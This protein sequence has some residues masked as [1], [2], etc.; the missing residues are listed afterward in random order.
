[1][2]IL[3]FDSV[4][5]QYLYFNE[6]YGNHKFIDIEN[7]NLIWTFENVD[8]QTCYL[9]SK[10]LD[11]IESNLSEAIELINSRRANQISLI[12]DLTRDIFDFEKELLFEHSFSKSVLHCQKGSVKQQDY[13]KFQF[14]TIQ[15]KDALKKL[16]GSSS[17][18]QAQIKKYEHQLLF[19]MDQSFFSI[20]HVSSQGQASVGMLV[21][22]FNVKDFKIIEY[23]NVDW[24]TSD[25]TD[26]ISIALHRE[27]DNNFPITFFIID[28][29]FSSLIDKTFVDEESEILYYEKKAIQKRPFHFEKVST[30]DTLRNDEAYIT[31]TELLQ[32]IGV[33][34]HNDLPKNW[35]SVTALSIIIRDKTIKSTMPILDAGGEYYSAITHQLAAFGYE[36][37]HCINTVFE[38]NS[39]IGEVHYLP[40]DITGTDFE[41][42]TFMAITCLSVIE[43]GVDIDKY[44]SEMSRILK[45]GGILFTST[46]YWIKPVDTFGK[47]AYGVPIK[48]F[49]KVD[50]EDIIIKAKTYGLALID[51]IN[52]DCVDK[53]VN[54]DGIEFTFIYFTFRKQPGSTS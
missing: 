9:N 45:P 7:D 27:N 35:D 3:T 43:H 24:N 54:W 22:E 42:N 20:K 52:Y 2:D 30:N 47:Q 10:Y 17:Q 49:N 28:K 29:I 36:N 26:F 4:I 46:D 51:P 8:S 41:E 25:C 18:Y 15:N 12:T 50:I 37:L 38:S 31:S 5:K 48:I 23:L 32:N 40:G 33:P 19:L 16:I 21:L 1:M 13:G 39:K 34:K 14:E 11:G 53:V 6:A 44:L